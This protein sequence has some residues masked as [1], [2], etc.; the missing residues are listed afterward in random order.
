MNDERRTTIDL[1]CDMGEGSG[2]DA[3]L[4]PLITSANIACGGHAGDEG[5]MWHTVHLAAAHHVGIGAHP[6]YPDREGFGRRAMAMTAA[7]VRREV[8]AQIRGLQSVAAAA[9]TSLQHVKPHGALYNQAAADRDVAA[10]IGEAVLQVD[11]SLI[12]VALAGSPGVTVLQQ[13]GLRVAGE[14]FVDRGYTPAGQLVARGD[15]GALIAD[16]GLAA[17][18]AVRAVRDH[19]LTAIDGTELE[20]HADTLCIHSDT[21]GSVALADAV[22]AALRDAGI[23]L[24]TLS[25]VIGATQDPGLRTQDAGRGS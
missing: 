7:Q 11:P 16:T 23:G 17:K 5:T 3:Q 9:G 13:M 12:V 10:A 21:P 15:S 24:A 19:A 14:A 2:V 25:D 18:R 20:M 8:A 6:S 1:N 22:R 4:M